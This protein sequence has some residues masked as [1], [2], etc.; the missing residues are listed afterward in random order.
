[1]PANNIEPVTAAGG[2]VYRQSG[3]HWDVLLIYRNGM[4]DLPKGMLEQDES[5]RECARREVA[6]ETGISPPEIKRKLTITKHTYSRDGKRY[7][8]T[9]H[10]FSMTANRRQSF[11]PQVEEGIEKVCWVELK[12]AEQKLGYE[13]L[14]EVIRALKKVLPRDNG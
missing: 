12:E 11:S 10:W 9:T 13:N 14:I 2:L 4:W 8:K 5:I 3:G 7:R 1:M 6:E